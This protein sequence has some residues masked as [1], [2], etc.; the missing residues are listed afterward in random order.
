MTKNNSHQGFFQSVLTQI[1]RENTIAYQ[2]LRLLSGSVHLSTEDLTVLNAAKTSI[3]KNLR[4][5]DA[6]FGAECDPAL[7]FK[8]R[9]TVK[10]N[11]FFS[12][13][14]NS[15]N[16][17]YSGSNRIQISVTSKLDNQRC[18]C[19][20]TYEFENM[21]CAVLYF[22][23]SSFS[24]QTKKQKIKISLTEKTTGDGFFS[25]AMSAKGESPS[26]QILTILRET[27]NLPEITSDENAL[28]LFTAQKFANSLSG[29]ICFTRRE[30]TNKFILKIPKKSVSPFEISIMKE[31]SYDPDTS[32]IRVYLQN[33]LQKNFAKDFLNVQKI[34]VE[35]YDIL[36]KLEK[37]GFSSY[38]VGG[39]VRDIIMNISPSD[40]DITTSASSKQVCEVFKDKKIIKTGEK[41]GT[42]TLISGNYAVEITTMRRDGEY[43][44]NRRPEEVFFTNDLAEDLKRRDFSINA[45]ALSFQGELVD[46]FEGQTHIKSKII[47]TVGDPN[48]RFLED[49]LRILRALRFAS[50]LGFEIE[51][52]TKAA[53]FENKNLLSNISAERISAE[54]EKLLC[55]DNVFEVLSEF[56]EVFAVIIPELMPCF[57]FCQNNPH[58]LHSVYAHSAMALKNA[59][60]DFEIRLALLLHD[61]AK[62]LC[63]TIGEDGFS[64]FKGHS[65]KGAEL[66][67]HILKRLKIANRK[68]KN[69]KNLVKFH[70][71][72]LEP[73]KKSVKSF[74]NLLGEE[75]TKKLFLLKLADESSKQGFPTERYAVCEKALT[76]FE[77][78]IAKN[79][80]Y[81]LKNLDINGD[82]L[83]NLGFEGEQIKKILNLL[84]DAVICEN[85]KNQKE[86]LLN[87]AKTLI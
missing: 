51:T 34:P 75:Q 31:A 41:F 33:A 4:F 47:K 69:I 86:D 64:H 82:D 59:P 5:I 85:T 21:I 65:K 35:I 44:N 22:L 23:F 15:I 76:I 46:I 87:S 57:D 20:N 8:K 24:D 30:K 26:L 37:S 32:Y 62:P 55:G 52:K 17:I 84:L 38:I 42:I 63:K 29:N 60:K 3:N 12:K 50:V 71:E 70:D 2:S 45:M 73:T 36:Q 77:D 49:S 11:E 58:H 68:A 67:T 10:I 13:L 28:N 25:F 19:I 7:L 79:E 9:K 80:C 72:K 39:A 48:E 54:L 53:I 61:I 18:F 78:I 40:F 16:D 1:H 43:K 27:E 83:K 74:L 81:S 56:K 6:L 66:T 14:A